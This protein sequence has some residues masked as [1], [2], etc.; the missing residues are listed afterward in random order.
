M[1]Q[2]FFLVS[3]LNLILVAALS[4][5]LPAAQAETNASPAAN[6]KASSSTKVKAPANTKTGAAAG[7][8]LSAKGLHRVDFLL[9]KASCATCILKVRTAFRASIG[10][11][12]SDIALRKPYGAVVIFDPSKIN[13]EKLKEVARLADPNHRVELVDPVE[14]AVPGVP[15][16]LYPLYSTLKKGP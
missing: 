16:L 3:C 10:V 8:S 12:A 14:K 13:F 2:K 11:A 15:T 9:E 5:S 7:A 4:L 6:S 1:R